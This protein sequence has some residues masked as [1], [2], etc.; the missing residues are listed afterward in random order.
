MNI[1]Y[2]ERAE[3]GW[4]KPVHLG[5]KVNSYS[6][7]TYPIFTQNGGLYF[8]SDREGGLGDKDLYYTRFVDDA[9]TKPVPLGDAI[10][11]EYGEGD[12]YVAF[13][14]SFMI[15]NTWGRPDCYG[16]G[17]LYISFKLAG[18]SWSKAKNMGERINTEFLEFCPMMSPDGKYLFFTSNRRG[19]GDIYWVDARVIEELKQDK[20][21]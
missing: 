14:E 21:K 10:N 19:N 1:W 4:A 13:D 3:S 7:D 20:L 16:S 15:I 18:G 11:S 8:G 6:S 2:C 5:T 17:D 12:T 9:Y